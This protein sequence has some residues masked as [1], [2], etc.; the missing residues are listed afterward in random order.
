MLVF[1]ISFYLLN[2]RNFLSATFICLGFL[3]K[4]RDFTLHRN[5][6]F[7]VTSMLLVT[8]GVIFWKSSMISYTPFTFMPY[9]LTALCGLLAM[10]GICSKL[11][12]CRWD[13]LKVLLKYIGDNT[14]TVL[15]WHMTAFL[16]VNLIIIKI[17]NI[18]F[19][20]PS[21]FPVIKEYASKGWG[22]L[23]FI[24][25]MIISCLMAYMSNHITQKRLE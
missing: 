21:V 14:L 13:K 16:L 9:F 24:T 12:Q 10:F 6:W 3:Y 15:T 25:Y 1:D 23:Y 11:E 7:I 2:S 19:C 8:I 22:I 4:Q 17:Y 5:S 18:D 20:K